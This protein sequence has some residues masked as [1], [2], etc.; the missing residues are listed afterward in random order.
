M[1]NVERIIWFGCVIFMVAILVLTNVHKSESVSGKIKQPPKIIPVSE[2]ESPYLRLSV[3]GTEGYSYG[4]DFK[5]NN[6]LS[7]DR[8]VIVKNDAN[9]SLEIHI[10]A[11]GETV[12]DFEKE[13]EDS[14]ESGEKIFQGPGDWKYYIDENWDP[15]P[16]AKA[17][18]NIRK[19]FFTE[20]D[21]VLIKAYQYD[22]TGGKYDKEIEQILSGVTSY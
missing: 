5:Y 6:N 10:G 18:D 4:T 16:N 22:Y 12:K 14:L 11:K 21:G 17:Y 9:L 20:K 3:N 2:E 15:T 8:I 19:V 13:I 7:G 1:Q